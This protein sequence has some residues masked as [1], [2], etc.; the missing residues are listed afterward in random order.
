MT[1]E[2]YLWK[3]ARD[4]AVGPD[5]DRRALHSHVGNTVQFLLLPDSECVSY[6]MTFI[7]KKI[8]RQ[9]VLLPELPVGSGAV[10]IDAEHCCVEFPEPGKGV[11][12]IARLTR[13]ARGVVFGIEKENHF[14]AAKGRERHTRSFV[15]FEIEI[16]SNLTFRD[17]GILDVWSSGNFAE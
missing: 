11:A 6:G 8:V 7:D 10:G 16:G 1:I 5:H 13:S 12:K 3:N 9:R 2:L 17:Q 4:A 15:G 14:A